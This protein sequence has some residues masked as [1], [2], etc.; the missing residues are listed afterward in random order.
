MFVR[1]KKLSF[2][3]LHQFGGDIFGPQDIIGTRLVLDYANC[4][5]SAE[6][7]NTGTRAR[8]LQGRCYLPRVACNV[9]GN[10]AGKRL[11]TRSIL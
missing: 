6:N 3:S 2:V 8:T 9:Y 1:N 7:R 4:S 11:S 5:C 10:K